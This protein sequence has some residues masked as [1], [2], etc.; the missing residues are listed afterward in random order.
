MEASQGGIARPYLKNEQNMGNIKQLTIILT[1]KLEVRGLERG[2]S[3]TTC[4]KSRR[5]WVK[6][7]STYINACP[8][9]QKLAG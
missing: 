6:I 4:C 5:A 8:G 3:K 2:L 9:F 1:V 7:P